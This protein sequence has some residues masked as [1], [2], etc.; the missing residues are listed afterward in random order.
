MFLLEGY[1]VKN[2]YVNR[3]KYVLDKKYPSLKYELRFF[4]VGDR[5]QYKNI[6]K[7]TYSLFVNDDEFMNYIDNANFL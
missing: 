2:K 4:D 3:L 7:Q 5:D 6:M 1:G